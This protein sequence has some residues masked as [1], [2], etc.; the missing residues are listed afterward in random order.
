MKIEILQN[1]NPPVENPLTYTQSDHAKHNGTTL[2]PT[3]LNSGMGESSFT[4]G[5]FDAIESIDT[6]PEVITNS[7]E[8]VPESITGTKVEMR[9]NLSGTIPDEKYLSLI[10]SSPHTVELQLS[11]L[12]VPNGTEENGE[13]LS[14]SNSKN[15]PK[16]FSETRKSLT[17]LIAPSPEFSESLSVP[18]KPNLRKEN[19][20]VKFQP[21]IEKFQP[22]HSNTSIG[23]VRE[24]PL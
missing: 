20:Y 21:S 7:V 5:D 23:S 16:F 9:K 2:S 17:D 8:F 15:T 19:Q 18:R 4:N 22:S 10:E 14:K 6:E 13:R 12:V 24:T 3:H 1:V 11:P